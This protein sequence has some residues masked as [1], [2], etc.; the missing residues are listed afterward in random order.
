MTTYVQDNYDLFECQKDDCKHN[1]CIGWEID[2]D[3]KTLQKYS[4][5]KGNFKE[6]L[7][8]NISL[9]GTPHFQ[10]QKG[11]R[12]PF[13]NEQ[14]LCDIITELGEDYLCE[15]CDLHP[16]FVHTYSSRKEI[17]LGLCCEEVAHLL[18]AK[19][20]P[21]SLVKIKED[22]Q[23]KKIKDKEKLF[24]ALRKHIFSIVQDRS[25][26]F[27]HRVEKLQAY[28]N[29]PE[30]LSVFDYAVFYQT[31][32]MLDPAWKTMLQNL[33]KCEQ[34]AHCTS[35]FTFHGESYDI[36]L[37]QLLCAFLFRHLT[38][39]MEGMY[40]TPAVLFSILS[41][42]MIDALIRCHVLEHKNITIEDTAQIIRA[43]SSEIEYSTQN[44]DEIMQ[45][46]CE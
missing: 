31:L 16:R 1:C 27:A 22:A 8:Q 17:G 7:D 26:P 37:E 18:L 40:L 45:K 43:Y 34:D 20:T 33:E 4:A 23:H 9:E 13:L 11:D 39:C 25:M 21:F 38:N 6:R 19:E 15:I 10:L 5:L 42:Q 3:E 41:V 2:V 46:L 35:S 12:C 28:C 32:E 29:R 36:V 24:F 14:G 44:V 30:M